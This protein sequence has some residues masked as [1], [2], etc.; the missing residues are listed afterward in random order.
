MTVEQRQPGIVG[1]EVEF[2]PSSPSVLDLKFVTFCVVRRG[3]LQIQK[4]CLKPRFPSVLI[5]SEVRRR[6][7][8]AHTNFGIETL[9]SEHLSSGGRGFV[10]NCQIQTLHE[11]QRVP[12]G[13]D[14]GTDRD[15]SVRR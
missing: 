5:D 11:K 2:Y 4:A 1:D 10:L 9:G 15:C 8:Q 13:P 3:E 12:S 14:A 6:P 7:P